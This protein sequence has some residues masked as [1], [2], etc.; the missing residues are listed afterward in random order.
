SLKV[1][2]LGPHPPHRRADVGRVLVPEAADANHAADEYPEE[3]TYQEDQQHNSHR[4]LSRRTLAVCISTAA[5]GKESSRYLSDGQVSCL[6]KGQDRLITARTR[7]CGNL[8]YV[9]YM[10]AGCSSLSA[11]GDMPAGYLPPGAG[12]ASRPSLI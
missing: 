7:Q 5:L 12:G 4:L 3:C 11:R 10:N 1:V 9:T 8:T 2:E 6:G